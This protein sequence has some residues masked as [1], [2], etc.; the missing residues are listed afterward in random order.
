M[1]PRA[2]ALLSASS[3]VRWINCPG[4][5]KLS[6]LF[7]ESPGSVYT[8]EGTLAHAMAEE[9]LKTRLGRIPIKLRKDIK[10]F[11]EGHP[12]LNGSY[13]EMEGY[14]IPY[15]EWVLEELTAMQTRLGSA[16]L[17]LEERFSMEEWIPEG[18]GTSDVVIYGAGELHIIDLKYGKGVA[19]SAEDNPQL[20]LYA[21]GTLNVVELITDIDTVSMSIYQPRLDNIST[22]KMKADELKA[23]GEN[24]VKPAA[25]EA[26]SDDARF[27]AGEAQCRWCPAKARCK[28]RAVSYSRLDTLRR[29]ALLSNKD[30]AK[31]LKWADGLD[32]WL[33]DI[34]DLALKEALE[35]EGI[36]GYKVV[37]GRS[38]RKYTVDDQ[39]IAKA[40]TDAGYDESLI[41]EKKLL[42]LSNMEKLVG[43]KQFPEIF[44]G[45]WEKPEGKPTLVPESDT[46]PAIGPKTAEDDFADDFE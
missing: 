1:A 6:E 40:A 7:P 24:V 18:F 14:I 26:L 45:M 42:T 11:Y 13:E 19:V 25:K 23:W 2:H 21:L 27:H 38:N 46:R 5:V 4:S 20:K 36:P 9:Y 12:E 39:T 30:I 44:K 32:S 16:E 17:K 3:A 43:K 35:G 34:K 41:W 8:E 10:A 15:C 37:E 29:Q 31:A 33:S 28:V 22:A